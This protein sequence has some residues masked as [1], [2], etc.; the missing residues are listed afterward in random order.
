MM[1][2]NKDCFRGSRT[3][4]AAIASC[5]LIATPTVM[6]QSVSA[7][8][9]G[10]VTSASAPSAGATVTAKNTLTG[11]TRSVQTAENGSYALAGLPPGPYEV[12]VSANGQTSS[13]L[14]V[15]Q[16]GQIA[17]L[18]LGVG[19][20]PEPGRVES[21]TVSATRLFETKTS[22]VS[23][24][25]SLKQIE[26]LPQSSRNFLEFADTI[27]GVQFQTSAD[28]STEVRSGGQSSNGVNVF[29]D[30]VGQ[31]NYVSRGGI[32]GQGSLA[33]GAG[34]ASRGT[35]GNP[36]P[37]LAIGEYKVI[38]SNY[39]AEFDQL[40][41][42]AIVA[43]T[44][45]GTNELEVDGFWDRTTES[46]RASDPFEARAGRKAPSEQEQYGA[47]VGGPIVQDRAHYFVT[48]EAKSFESPRRV[49]AASVPGFSTPLPQRYAGLLG[50]FAQPFEEDLL[51]AKLDWSPGDAHLFQLSGKWREE[52]E[53][54]FGDNDPPEHATVK[55]NEDARYDL[56]YQYTGASFLNDAHITYEDSSFQFRPVTIAPGYQLFTSTRD[57]N[58]LLLTYGATDVFEERSQQGYGVQNDLTFNAFEW[59]G[60]H[61]IKTGVKYKKIE[62]NVHTESP[63]NPVY[64][65]DVNDATATPWRVKFGAVLPFLDDATV[66]SEN[67][68]YS[69][70]VQDDWDVTERLQL[71]LGLRYDYEKTPAY[72][73]YRTPA[74][75]V[76]ALNRQDTNPGDAGLGHPPAPAGQTYAQTLARGGIDVNDYISTGSNRDADDNDIAPR[77]GFSFDLNGDQR[78]VIFG[79]AG[80]SYDRNVFE[81]IARETFKGAYPTYTRWFS[82]PSLG[83]PCPT[84]SA[85]NTCLVW[86]PSYLNR[87]VLRG[88]VAANPQ[89][90]REI[91]MLNN[92][93]DTP[94]SDQ[95]SLGMRNRIVLGSQD[96]VTSLAVS[97]IKS[98]EGI[99]FT[100]GN[101]WPD[102]QFRQPGTIWG[103]QPWGSGIP[104]LGSLIIGNNG[105][106]T[107]TKQVL[108]SLEKPYSSES[109]WGATFAYTFSD[110]Q[111][112]R[113]NTA[114]TDE[115]YIFD[116]AT[117]DEFGWHQSTGVPK[118]RVVATAIYDGPW[119]ITISS[120]LTL[121]TPRYID[122]NNCYDA[123]NVNFCFPD[124]GQ[125]DTSIGF[126][127]LDLAFQ[128]QFRFVEDFAI[129]LRA[130]VLN[131]FNWANPDRRNND[132]GAYGVANPRYLEIQSYYQPTRTF[133]LSFSANWR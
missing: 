87:D 12:E 133:K 52:E 5:L 11:L 75:L 73:D 54:V 32:A 18:D 13:Q 130:D 82:A 47:A 28:G 101:R 65:I 49:F 53:S 63:F 45:S 43:V 24:Y 111:E 119:D 19:A 71:N 36:F 113:S 42:A 106:E 97:Y 51:F 123:P 85:P 122:T 129:R 61:S 93:I 68:Q 94:Y 83:R 100:L 62:L 41:S 126:K 114:G 76:A 33:D 60:S 6:G 25:V 107:R 89:L 127:Q 128:K 124:P 90:G 55:D 8:L 59:G 40:S 80:R 35:R 105:I 16:V 29:I 23:N 102:G 38:T 15:L 46:W 108:L 74:D 4:R 81:Y 121:A 66:E 120:K 56:R 26:S 91:F 131:V 95:Y 132:R 3:L 64:G 27:P 117:I 67:S 116:F 17:T 88:L 112:N 98:E 103:G 30:G 92:E 84:Q 2:T 1:S 78:N 69:F 110:A 58:N 48:Y 20:A 44:K 104:G 109:R 125:P 31:K 22:E 77:I 10:Q 14:V 115:T 57:D 37:Q 86:D 79:G 7:T 72:L 39:K 99:A 50:N 96:Y 34:P 70:Y 21:V 9:R 118:H